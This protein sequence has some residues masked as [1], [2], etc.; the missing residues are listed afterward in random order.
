[1]ASQYEHA[2]QGPAADVCWVT[3]KKAGLKHAE[4]EANPWKILPIIR[5]TK[6]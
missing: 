3:E 2:L 6:R 5:S 1:M 4:P